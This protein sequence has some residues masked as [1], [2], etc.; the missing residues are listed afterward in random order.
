VSPRGPA[1]AAQRR[2]PPHLPSDVLDTDMLDTG[3]VRVADVEGTAPTRRRRHVV[4][5]GVLTLLAATCYG[6]AEFQRFV[7]LGAGTYDLVIFDQAVRSYSHFHLPL[8]MVAGVHRG[9]GTDFSLLG[10]HFSPIL[11]LLA[12]LYWIHSGPQTLLVAQALLFAGAIPPL[13]VFARRELGPTAAYCV[14]VGYAVAWPVAQAVTFD[15]HEVAFVPLLTAILFERFSVYR[16]DRGRWWHLVLPAI[17]LL[18]VKED[19]GLLVAGFGAAVLVLSARWVTPRRR[20]ARWLGAGF[21]V[22]GLVAVVVTI[23]VVLPAFGSNPTFYWSYGR[24]GPN[25]TSA[26]WDMLTHPG[27]VATTLVTPDVKVQTMVDLFAI[28]MF[29][30]LCSPFVLMILPLLAERMLSGAPNWWGL[31]FHYNAFLVVALLCAGVDGV[32]RPLRWWA[33]GR[34]RPLG[35]L[36]AVAVALFGVSSVHDF[37]FDPVLHSSSWQRT[38]DTRAAADAVA[39]VPSGVTV[40]AANSLGPWLTE[41]TTVVLWDLVPRWTPW[42]VADVR[43]PVFPFCGPASQQAQVSRLERDGYQVVFAEDG[44]LVLHHPGPLPPLYAGRSPGCS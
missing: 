9:F 7:T 40:S 13:W 8:S 15:F 28:A 2:L 24:F 21:V 23:D 34:A 12:P 41:R 19:M 32:V 17:G 42:V 16:R 4:G 37:A 26:A 35:A 29:A 30:A 43:R 20:E 22:G 44:Y 3:D 25:M 1:D 11:A 36:W 38:A 6:L 5:V 14:V 18:G 33:R 39:H 10:D 31:D 27:T